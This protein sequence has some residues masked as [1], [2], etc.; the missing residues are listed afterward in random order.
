VSADEEHA[1][2]EADWTQLNAIVTQAKSLL[3]FIELTEASIRY[4]T[5]I[6]KQLPELVK[7][8]FPALFAQAESLFG[9]EAEQSGDEV[10]GLA[11]AK[12][13]VRSSVP[14][15]ESAAMDAMNI[16]G[17]RQKLNFTGKNTRRAR[18]A[19]LSSKM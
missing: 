3:D 17:F 1:K 13:R 5:L 9:K 6:R 16:I 18:K 2:P 10:K 11:A 19:H 7:E 15:A 12:S 4:K 8:A 14:N